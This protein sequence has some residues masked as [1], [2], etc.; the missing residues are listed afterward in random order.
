MNQI[1]DWEGGCQR[2]G[3]EADAHTMSMFD[4]ALICMDCHE[5]EMQHPEFDRARDAE[6]SEIKR[7]N[8]NFPGVGYPDSNSGVEND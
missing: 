5:N 3:A 4:V 1:R 2:C 7:G 8:M 6:V